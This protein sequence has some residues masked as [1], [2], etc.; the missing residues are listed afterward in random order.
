MLS[1]DNLVT[2]FNTPRGVVR[3]VDG[4]SLS[5]TRGRAVGIV[6]ESGSGKTVLSRSI[7]GLVSGAAVSRAGSVRFEGTEL[8][9][10]SNREL[11]Q[12]WGR[13]MSTVFQDPMA[14]L[15]PLM[16]IGDQIAEPLKVHLG[17]DRSNATEIAIRL[18]MEVRIPEP[19]RRLRQY[20]HELSGGMRQRVMIAIALACGPKLLI[21]DEPTTALDVTVQAQILNLIG[22]QRRE[23]DMALLL[24]THDLGVVAGHTDEIYVM[25]AGQVVERAPT[26]TLFSDMRMPYTEALMDSIPNLEAPSHTR[27]RAIGGRPPDLIHPPPGCRFAPRCPYARDRCRTEQPPL[28]DAGTPGHQFACWYPVG[29]PEYAERRLEIASRSVP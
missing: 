5:V 24:V 1:V 13:S 9:G 23:R 10:R 7:M 26:T 8:I 11:R 12:I 28:E 18:L 29:S 27:L 16:R 15:N 6:G 2:H 21:A 17:L 25:Y 3:A 19:A 14:S 20:P 22:E 4:V